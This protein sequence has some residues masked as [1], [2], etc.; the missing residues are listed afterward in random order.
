MNKDSS[1]DVQK[2]NIHGCTEVHQLLL[3]SYTILMQNAL[4]QYRLN[5]YIYMC[6]C[7]YIYVYI[8][9]CIY[10]Y[11]Y[12]ILYIIYYKLYYIYYI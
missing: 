12:I 8:Y 4:K 3:W 6:V 5:I 11:I 7:V 1:V 10:I 2:K 9:K